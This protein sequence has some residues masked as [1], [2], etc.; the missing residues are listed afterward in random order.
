MFLLHVRESALGA[1][2]CSLHHNASALVT[3]DVVHRISLSVASNAVCERHSEYGC[4]RPSEQLRKPALGACGYDPLFLC[5]QQSRGSDGRSFQPVEPTLPTTAVVNAAVE[6][7]AQLLPLQ[8]PTIYIWTFNT[9]LEAVLSSKLEKNICCR[10]AIMVYASIA[11]VLALRNAMSSMHAKQARD[12]L[13]STQ[14]TVSIPHGMSHLTMIR[15][16]IAYIHRR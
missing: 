4:G 15:L 5:Q 14:S 10:V 16:S 8:E 11:I 13:G 6:P 1:V 2:L 9:L 3:L 7:F 12:V